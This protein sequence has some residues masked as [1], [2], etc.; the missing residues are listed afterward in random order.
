[1]SKNAKIAVIIEPRKHKA[2]SFVIKN[3]LSVLDKSWDIYFYHGT[4]N[5]EFARSVLPRNNRLHYRSVNKSNLTPN[6]YNSLLLSK[7]FWENLPGEHVLIFQT[8]SYLI[9][10]SK[11]HVN[12]YLKY[13]FIGAPFREDRRIGCGGLSLRRRSSALKALERLNTRRAFQNAVACQEDRFFAGIF[14]RSS[15]YTFPTFEVA[16]HFCVGTCY[17][18]KPFAVHQFWTIGLSNAE[19]LKLMQKNPGLKTLLALQEKDKVAVHAKRRAKLHGPLKT[20]RPFNPS[21]P[22]ARRRRVR[23]KIP[24]TSIRASR[25]QKRQHLVRRSKQALGFV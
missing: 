14:L 12:E 25:R 11:H 20:A 4:T 19:Y 5:E 16:K 1:M 22:N 15:E 2:L 13:D 10:D 23:R 17:Y 7:E 8:D 18:D 3:A 21:K 24:T 9:P 6:Q